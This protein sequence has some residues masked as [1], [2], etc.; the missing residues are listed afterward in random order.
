MV[1]LRFSCRFPKVFLRFQTQENRKKTG[2]KPEENKKKTKRKPKENQKKTRRNPHGETA[3]RT[4][5]CQPEPLE[6]LC[7]GLHAR[8][9]E[10]LVVAQ[11]PSSPCGCSH[12]CSSCARAATLPR[13]LK[14][15][16]G[17]GFPTVFLRFSYGFLMVF[18]RFS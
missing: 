6:E 7:V 2:R 4:S 10:A 5:S 1:F 17:A 14:R 15:A 12:G 18:L 11:L 9:P 13:V 16:F 3:Y 8:H